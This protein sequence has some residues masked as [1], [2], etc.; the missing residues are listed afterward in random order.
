MVKNFNT[1]RLKSSSCRTVIHPNVFG[2][3]NDVHDVKVYVKKM[4]SVSVKTHI[5]FP[6]LHVFYLYRCNIGFA[7]LFSYYLLQF[8]GHTWIFSNMSARFVSFG[9]G[10]MQIWAKVNADKEE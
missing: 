8:C 6:Q 7:Y 4:S 3:K 5:P 2:N 9:F 10:K 1:E